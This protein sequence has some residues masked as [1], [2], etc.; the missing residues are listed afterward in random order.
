MEN[1]H[2]KMLKKQ[3]KKTLYNEYNSKYNK[4]NTEYNV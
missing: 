4:E 1:A 3:N 2:S